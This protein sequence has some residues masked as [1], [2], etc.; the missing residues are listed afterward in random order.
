M[1]DITIQRIPVEDMTYERFSTEFLLPE[2]PVIFGGVSAGEHAAITPGYLK[3]TFM[4]EDKRY[5]GWF[6][7]ALVDSGPVRVPE[8]VRCA[9]SG[10]LR[11]S[12]GAHATLDAAEGTS[13][14]AALR[15]Q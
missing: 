14:V 13:H 15:W 4:R 1:R 8:I 10:R 3:R 9:V 6:E 11:S 7:S 12:S 2:I 5:F